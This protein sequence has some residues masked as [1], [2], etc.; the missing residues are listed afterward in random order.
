MER[1][2]WRRVGAKK[3]GLTIPWSPASAALG[4]HKWCVERSRD[5]V[6]PS[7]GKTPLYP[8]SSAPH[9]PSKELKRR[10]YHESST[11]SAVTSAVLS[12]VPIEAVVEVWMLW[13]L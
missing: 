4:I 13:A 8:P 6:G 1:P 11:E 10:P 12:S 9:Y 3:N 7:A 5:V 2:R